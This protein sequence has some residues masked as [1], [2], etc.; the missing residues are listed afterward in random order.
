MSCGAI[1]RAGCWQGQGR[2]IKNN[3]K[4]FEFF[5]IIKPQATLSLV[6]YLY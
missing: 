6:F 2:V 5:K 1:D 4:K 3:V